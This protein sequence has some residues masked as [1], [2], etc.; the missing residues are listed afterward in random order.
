MYVLEALDDVLD[1]L[2]EAPTNLAG[3]FGEDET[4]EDV[5]SAEVTEELNR[6]KTLGRLYT[7]PSA[8]EL[9]FRT[10]L[11]SQKT[12]EQFDKRM[13]AATRSHDALFVIPRTELS[14]GTKMIR[15]RKTVVSSAG[16]W[17]LKSQ[18]TSPTMCTQEFQP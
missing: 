1:V 10:F 9:M 4:D 12:N 11:H 6:L 7:V 16:S 15:G 13:V 2:F 14:L 8:D 3:T 5:V 18:E 17:Q